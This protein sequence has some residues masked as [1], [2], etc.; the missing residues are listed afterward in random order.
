MATWP[1]QA[2]TCPACGVDQDVSIPSVHGKHRAPRGGDM[3]IC[4][5]CVTILVFRQDG[6]RLVFQV[7]VDR[8]YWRCTPEYLGE[9]QMIRAKAWLLRAIGE[10]V[11]KWS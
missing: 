7:A 1:H 11:A 6:D 2:I 4:A 5:H 10:V 3:T 8:D 9:L